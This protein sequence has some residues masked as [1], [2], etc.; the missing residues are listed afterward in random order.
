MYMCVHNNKCEC[1]GTLLFKTVVQFLEE[2]N[3][4]WRKLLD[5]II[6][7]F[8]YQMEFVLDDKLNKPQQ[9]IVCIKYAV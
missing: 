3:K 9:K 1:E 5:E 4:M 8:Q 7:E 2:F 6:W